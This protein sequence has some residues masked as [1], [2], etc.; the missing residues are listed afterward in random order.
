M[1]EAKIE[2][3]VT[4]KPRAELVKEFER[5]SGDTGSPE[6][7]VALLT[8]RVRRLTEHLGT[9]KKDHSTRRGL[10]MLVGQRTKLLR[11]LARGDLTRYQTLIKRLGLRK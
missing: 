11:Y 8:Q 6:V 2:T 1:T 9:H 3:M 10:L 4:D 5:A 7:Q